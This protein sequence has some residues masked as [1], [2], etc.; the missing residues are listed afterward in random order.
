MRRAK[1][2]SLDTFTEDYVFYN[3]SLSMPTQM[4]MCISISIYSSA[5]PNSD[6]ILS[7]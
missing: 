2:S 7:F 1:R 4:C 3:D 5:M 6:A